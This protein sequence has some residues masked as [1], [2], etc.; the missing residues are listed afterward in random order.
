[1]DWPTG[2]QP[3]GSGLRIRLW[4]KSRV[5]YSETLP[6]DPTSK[7][8]LSAAV[9]RREWLVAR[10]K[11]GLPL[12][13]SD[14]DNETR[15]FRQVARDYLDTL[16]AKR[17]TQ[18]SYRSLMNT[19]WA[20]FFEWPIQDITAADIKRELATREVSRKTKRNALIVLRGVLSH[21]EVFPN[22]AD[23]VK[24]RRDQKKAIQRYLPAERTALLKQLTGQV[25]VYFALMFGCGLRPG[26]VRGLLWTDYNGEELSVTKQI[27]RRR[28]EATTKTYM[29]RDVYVPLWVRAYL[30]N[31]STR[32]N[33]GYIFQTESGG[34]HLDTDVFNEEWQRAHKRARIPYRIPYTCRHTRAAE[35][36]STGVDPVDAAEQLGHSLEMFLRTY[37]ELIKEYATPRDKSRFEGLAAEIPPRKEG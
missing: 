7:T 2:I 9:K 5:I 12:Y 25:A 19:Y 24:I 21:A 15:A 35:L 6:G 10:K 1:M 33:G 4:H 30:N 36:L 31:H 16:D 34:P 26:E 22:P 11:L 28:P 14:D 8:L 27:T 17:S 32:F 20:P 37:S 23:R 29:R 3:D 18:M 13:L